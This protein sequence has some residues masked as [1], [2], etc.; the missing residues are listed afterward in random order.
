MS[1]DDFI[2][3]HSEDRY[4]LVLLQGEEQERGNV[5]HTLWWERQ[6][7]K[8]EKEKEGTNTCQLFSQ[9]GASTVVHLP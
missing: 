7:S 3:Q 8:R 2:V 9:F 4:D 6:K 1:L 5:C